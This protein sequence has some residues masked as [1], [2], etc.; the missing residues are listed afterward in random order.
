MNRPLPDYAPVPLHDQVLELRKQ[1]A[2]T[3]H[4]LDRQVA[5]GTTLP[6]VAAAELQKLQ[7]ALRTVE[8]VEQVVGPGGIVRGPGDLQRAA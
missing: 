2:I 4:V 1:L 6:E 8:A 3:Q 5:R 7:S